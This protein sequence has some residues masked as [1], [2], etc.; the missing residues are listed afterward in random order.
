[1]FILLI[2]GSVIWVSIAIIQIR[3][4]IF[5]KKLRKILAED[6]EQAQRGVSPLPDLDGPA[7]PTAGDGSQNRDS[8]YEARHSSGIVGEGQNDISIAPPN[9]AENESP[10]SVSSFSVPSQE[11]A[12]AS[13]PPTNLSSRCEVPRLPTTRDCHEAGGVEYWALT[14][15]SYIVSAYFVLFQLCGCIGLGWW[16]SVHMPDIPLRNGLNPWW[17]GAFNAVSAFNNSGMSLLDKNM[18]SS[19]YIFLVD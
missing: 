8:V 6:Q 2:L 17:M 18:V 3:K 9:S 1:M 12:L 16:I 11:S 4:T 19:Y 15:L 10:V 7:S 5:K 13:A 14:L